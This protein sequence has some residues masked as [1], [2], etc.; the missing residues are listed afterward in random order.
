MQSLWL[1]VCRT[2][3]QEGC[4]PLQ[5]AARQLTQSLSKALSTSV[6]QDLKLS[7]DNAEEEVI[8]R[9]ADDLALELS[10]IDRVAL[11]HLPTWQAD[12]LAVKLIA[13]EDAVGV[14]G[15]APQIKS[16]VCRL[17]ALEQS[18]SFQARLA[19]KAESPSNGGCPYIQEEPHP[20]LQNHH[21]TAPLADWRRRLAQKAESPSNGGCPYIQEE[22]HPSL[23]NNHLTAPLADWRRRRRARRM[24]GAEGGEPVEWWVPLHP[25]G[26]SSLTAKQPPDCPPCR[27][28]QEVESLSD[29]GS[30]YIQEEPH[31]SLQNNHLT[32]PLADWRRRRR[33]RR[34]TGADGGEPVEWWV[35]LH[36]RGASSLTAKQPPDCPP[37]RL[38]QEVE[39]LSDGGSP[40]SE[41]NFAYGFTAF[42]SWLQVNH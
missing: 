42:T 28:A 21:L 10:A 16:L 31:P 27:L 26:A 41:E 37:C 40:Y 7:I 38:A 30:P 29:G 14:G 36:P 12:D 1:D 32:A 5:A 33:A 23:Q 2:G 22:P 9:R 11:G 18:I 4:S 8:Q 15:K 24:T 6:V 19:Q 35:P 3:T 13:M 25:R 20:S 34:M 17:R 39:R